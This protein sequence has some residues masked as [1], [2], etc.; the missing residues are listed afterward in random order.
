[1]T[2]R[3]WSHGTVIV[4]LCLGVVMTASAAYAQYW[5]SF[6]DDTRYMAL[7]DSL[8]AGYG[9][10]PSTQGFVYGLYQS[11]V[12]DNV[13]NTLLCNIGVPNATSG[14]VRAYQ[15]PQVALF[16]ADTGIA[17]R[18]VIT[19]TVG[20]NDLQQ[21][22]GGADPATVLNTLAVNLSAILGTLGG[23]FP[24]AQ[25]YVA[26]QYDPGLGLPGEAGLIAAAN[27]LIAQVVGSVPN[28]TL[29]DVFSAFQGRSGLLLVERK[30]ADQLQVHPTNAGYQVM[31]KTFADAIGK[32]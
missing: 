29:V 28:A 14:D 18:Q 27:V 30:G 24:L 17:Y 23:N 11:G 1:M 3:A 7:G 6:A 19:L 8:S 26:N 31:Q 13:N 25:I 32:H 21:I 22:L 16:F 5:V 9:A 20:G 15:V 10:H 12:I 4:V 2:K